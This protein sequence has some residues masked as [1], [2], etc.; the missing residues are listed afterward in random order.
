MQLTSL[1]SISLLALSHVLPA[2]S[3]AADTLAP[4]VGMWVG[5]TSTGE[6]KLVLEERKQIHV[7]DL[8]L[9]DWIMGQYSYVT[10]DG[11]VNE[12]LS[13]PAGK[14]SLSCATDEDNSGKIHGSFIDV[15]S[16]RRFDIKMSFTNAERTQLTWSI[17]GRQEYISLGPAKPVLTGVSVPTYVILTKVK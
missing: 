5:H 17:T 4:Y 16:H 2:R 7:G 8:N 9:G 10:Q 6:F 11:L 1:F 15:A 3:Q 14:F 13:L 12:S